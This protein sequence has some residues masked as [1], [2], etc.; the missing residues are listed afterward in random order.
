M[1]ERGAVS[2]DRSGRRGRRRLRR[3]AAA[4]AGGRCRS[5]GDGRGEGWGRELMGVGAE[6][7]AG[8]SW[9]PASL[10]CLEPERRRWMDPEGR[11]S[12]CSDRG[13][14]ETVGIAR[15]GEIGRIELGNVSTVFE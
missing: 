9:P 7:G 13:L 5:S 3:A 10:P 1:Y 2:T 11:R 8:A 6:M 4:T 15:W 12:V 14:G